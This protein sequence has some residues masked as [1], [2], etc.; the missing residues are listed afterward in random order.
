MPVSAH[1]ESLLRKHEQALLEEAQVALM[2]VDK[3][4]RGQTFNQEILPR[5][6]PVVEAIGHRLA[7]DAASDAG[8]H[9][10]LLALYEC[11][12]INEDIGWYIENHLITRAEVRARET[13]A[14]NSLSREIPTL[15]GELGVESYAL[16]PIVSDDA[17][18]Q[19]LTNL[20][21]FGPGDQVDTS[22]KVLGKL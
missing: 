16:A 7:Y 5:C 2:S 21:S 1:P 12:V 22:D 13:A 20:P 9:P 17:W 6:R 11:Q 4:H 10:A 14:A 3:K 15:L 18:A 19:F 8:V